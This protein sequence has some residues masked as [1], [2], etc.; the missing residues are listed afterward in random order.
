MVPSRT[1]EA[2]LLKDEQDHLAT[3]KASMSDDQLE[4]VIAKTIELKKIQAAE[5]PPEAR[6]T[7]PSLQLSDLKR[8]VSE[9]P[10]AVSENEANS[11]VTVVR[12]EMGS[13]SGIAY[14]ALGLDISML[15]LEDI[16]LLPLMTR[17]MMETGAGD[18]DSG[19]ALS[20]RIG[21]YTGGIGVNILDTPVKRTGVAG[22]SSPSA[23]PW[24]R[25]VKS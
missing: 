20:Q 22:T 14:A 2:K 18:Y 19:V 7:I 17:I 16:P 4:D 15:P 12:H 9:Y 5:D 23:K 6:A 21:I 25:N 8:E 10:I 3:I 1:L 24:L 11:G 13:T